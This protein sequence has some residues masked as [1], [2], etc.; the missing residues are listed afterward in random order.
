MNKLMRM[1]MLLVLALSLGY[2]AAVYADEAAEA[3]A[4][5][6]VDAATIEKQIAE[7]DALIKF[8]T[9]MRD[10]APVKYFA[11]E[12]SFWGPM[13]TSKVREMNMHCDAIINSAKRL[14]EELAGFA[15]WH[16]EQSAQ[17]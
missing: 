8:H 10:D 9:K 3:K 1:M 5:H 15:G 16:K 6:A 14:K 12:K 4:D 2:S 17:E 7:Q 11:R 13:A